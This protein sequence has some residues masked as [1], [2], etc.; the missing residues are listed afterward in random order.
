MKDL[1][2]IFSLL[3]SLLFNQT[4]SAQTYGQ[5]G[6]T[7][8]GNGTVYCPQMG[9]G[10]VSGGWVVDDEGN[11]VECAKNQ[12][13]CREALEEADDAENPPEGDPG[14][15][16]GD[17]NPTTP[18]PADPEDEEEEES[19]ISQRTKLAMHKSRIQF[20]RMKNKKKG[21]YIR[22]KGQFIYIRDWQAHHNKI[23][24]SLRKRR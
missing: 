13:A 12:K 3:F 20:Q 8:Y 2:Y 24:A 7:Y 6:C 21:L 14:P 16:N 11:Y 19:R 1:I 5:H 17:D 18:T 10:S 23:L 15:S 4:I 22:K 9:D